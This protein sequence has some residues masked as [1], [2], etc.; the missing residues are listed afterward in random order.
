MT[1]PAQTALRFAL[2]CLLGAGLGLLYG[3]LRPLRPRRTALADSLFVAAALAAWVYLSFGIC[4]GDVRPGY[5]AAL[6]LGA[7]LW[8]ATAGRPL[9]RVFQGFWQLL[10]SIF[11]LITLPFRKIF[12]KIRIFSKKY[13]HLR[14]KGVQ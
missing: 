10:G 9:R 12:K 7:L 6:G 5:T 14:K 2:G 13:L 11:S 8:E 1:A 4:R 3:F